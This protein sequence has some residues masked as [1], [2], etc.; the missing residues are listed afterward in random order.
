MPQISLVGLAAVAAVA[1]AVPL[2]LGFVPRIRLPA[3]VLE[4]LAGIVIGP[5]GFGWVR[6]DLPVQIFSVI[7]LGFVLLLA[8]L[9]VGFD[10]LRGR[11]LAAAL[12]NFAA[13]LGL[14][15]LV[16]Y[17]LR[18]V[19]L[20]QSPLFI[21]VVLAAT[22]LGVVIPILKDAGQHA[23]EFGQLVIA[24]ASIADFGT[25]IL[26]SVLFSGEAT[27]TGAKAVLLGAFVVLA[28]AV[29]LL[30]AR[31][32]RSMRL[33]GIL[34]RLQDTT[35]QIRVRGAFLL[36]AAFIALAQVLG[37]E[38]IFAAFTV[39]V[40]LKLVDPDEM[41]ER[42]NVRPKLEAAGYGVFVPMFFVA[43]GLQFNV[44]ALVS[45]AATIALVPVFF[46]ALLVIRGL[47]AVLYRPVVGGRR[48]FAAAMLQAT[49][50]GFI[51][52]AAQVGMELH[53]LSQATGAALIAA[54][55]LSVITFPLTALIVLGRNEASR[56]IGDAPGGLGATGSAITERM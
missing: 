37:L 30:I 3:V 25:I 34:A 46:A 31:A 48:A 22:S 28:A 45:S 15:A 50:L 40:I 49:S 38:V 35:A 2:L 7:G 29:G 51:V 8:G 44:G 21:A 56:A 12:V 27:H 26:L 41:T 17:A 53:L 24:A 19:G 42:S 47:P 33:S 55:L 1:F 52:V 11:L 10:R 4:I 16:A 14:A 32:A 13:S 6:V 36:L 5:S 18:A 20:V 43:S 9:E 54:G 39:G 23:S